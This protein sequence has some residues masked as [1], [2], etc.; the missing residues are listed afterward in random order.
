MENRADVNKLTT[1]ASA[2]QKHNI[3]ASWQKTGNGKGKGGKNEAGRSEEKKG[4]GTK[5]V[6]WLV[7]PLHSFDVAM[8]YEVQPLSLFVAYLDMCLLL[9]LLLFQC[10]R[11]LLSRP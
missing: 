4:G 6:T 9:F 8:M 1:N 5:C 7:Q 11:P 3:K 10:L 2:N